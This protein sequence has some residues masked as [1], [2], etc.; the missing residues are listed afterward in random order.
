MDGVGA[1]FGVR[2]GED[3]ASGA[4]VRPDVVRIDRG[5]G[6]SAA[7]PGVV[8]GVRVGGSAVLN[9]AE[10]WLVPEQG[11]SATFSKFF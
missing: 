8:M 6:V 7:Q 4:V 11:R 3:V 10:T 1:A 9:R 5:V 2:L